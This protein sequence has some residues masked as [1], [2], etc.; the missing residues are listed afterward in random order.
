MLEGFSVCARLS[1]AVAQ[2]ST[3]EMPGVLLMSPIPSNCCP[4]LR[5]LLWSRG[6]KGNG[7]TLGKIQIK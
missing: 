2:H 3:V 4:E 1:M 6:D 5:T 7:Q